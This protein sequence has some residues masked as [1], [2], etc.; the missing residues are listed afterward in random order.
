MGKQT[1]K[2]DTR[3]SVCVSEQQERRIWT[4]I[5]SPKTSLHTKEDMQLTEVSLAEAE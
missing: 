3:V 2:R 1:E 4:H 5:E